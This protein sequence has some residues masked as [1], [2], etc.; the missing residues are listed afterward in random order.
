MKGKR[1]VINLAAA[2]MTLCG[3]AQTVSVVRITTESGET[4]DILLSEEPKAFISGEEVM[5]ETS[6]SMISFQLEG[7]PVMEIITEVSV[8]DH[9]APDLC[10][11]CLHGVLRITGNEPEARVSIFDTA[12]NRIKSDV[13]KDSLGWEYDTSSLNPNVYILTIDNRNFKILIK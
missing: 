9:R 4:T 10:V 3:T 11:S 6:G 1:L 8:A 7:Q 13:I 2:L 12:G 5:V